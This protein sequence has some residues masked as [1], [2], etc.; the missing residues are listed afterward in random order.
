M[1]QVVKVLDFCYG[2]RLLN[3]DGK[4]SHPHGHNG[5]VEIEFMASELDARGMVLDFVEIKTE[6]KRFLDDELDHKMILHRDDP[7]TKLL[8]DLGEPVFVM[9]ENPTAENIARV[10]FQYAHS[11][12]LPVKSVRLWE[13]RTSYAQFG[14]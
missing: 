11:R 3:Y 4:C 6:V 10:I 2:H 8:K 1:Y 7:L 13:T 14:E 5:K 9:Q 12:G